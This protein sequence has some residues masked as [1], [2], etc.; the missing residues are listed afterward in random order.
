MKPYHKI[1]SI[2]KRDPAAKHKNFL[3]GEYSMPEFKYLADCQWCMTEKVDGTNIRVHW[4]GMKVAFGG[5]T[6]NADIPATLVQW[7]NA[8]FSAEQMARLFPDS[9]DVT[10][11]GEGYGARIQKG[12]GDYIPD[13]VAFILFDVSIGGIWLNRY[14]VD[15][16]A[17]RLAISVVPVVMYGTLHEAVELVKNGF[18]S[19]IAKRD[20][21]IAEGVIA[22]PV[23]PLQTRMG[24]RIITKIKC[25]D[26]N[27]AAA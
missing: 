4:D 20:D 13:G 12:G 19:L 27:G 23:T 21:T 2:Y 8:H 25:R 15:E 7:L 1:N 14:S 11:Y 9:G 22:L 24:Q 16:I 10:L 6:D 26:F 18:T 3:L 17:E 5:R